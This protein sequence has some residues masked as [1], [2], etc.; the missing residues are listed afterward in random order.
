MAVKHLLQLVILSLPYLAPAHADTNAAGDEITY[1]SDAQV[2][3]RRDSELFN[4]ESLPQAPDS[5]QQL[6]PLVQDSGE[7]GA[8]APTQA[9]SNDLW[10]RIKG[11][12]AMPELRSPFTATHESWYAARP[13]YVRRMVGRSQKYLYHIV[14]EVQKR[15]MPTEIALLP[16]VES[17]FNPQANSTSRASGIWQFIPSTGKHFGLKQDW[18]V[19]NRRDVMAATDAALD[20]LQKLHVMFGSWDLALAA[21]NAGEG[22]VMRAIERNR[23]QG[24][25][26]DYQS[27][28]LPAE[29]K[30]YVPKLQAVKNIVTN[31]EQYGLDIRPIANQPYFTT[32][33]AP[34]QIDAS[35][36]AKLAGISQEEFLALNPE[37]NRPV[38]TSSGPT[39]EFLLPVGKAE[40]FSANLAAYNQPLVS[41]QTYN[42]KRGERQD[43]IARKFGISLAQLRDVNDI[44]GK[45]GK[46]SQPSILLVP[47]QT[48]GESALSVAETATQ[49]P[50]QAGA[51]PD[52]KHHVVKK[53]DSVNS[54]AKRYDMSANS[55]VALNHLKSRKL[56]SGQVLLVRADIANESTVRTRA[57]SAPEKIHYVVRRGDT[58]TEIARKFDVATNDL[59]R[60]NRLSGDRLVPGHKLTIFKPDA[61]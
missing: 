18:W 48:G 53:G 46:L 23:K 31:P 28:S 50:E 3:G 41:W 17:A 14:E 58:L 56:R 40:E 15:G 1:Y 27:L 52:T 4:Y 9:N 5:V 51:T 16:M 37:Y 54:V 47:A 2:Y 39:H 35:L 20:Y 13:D 59:Q 60:W 32:V 11:G 19:D 26:T 30:N 6:P 24:L 55:L 22:T 33:Q 43:A 36:A 34:K 21:Y 8:A 12:Y 44:V 38:L 10:Q 57:S 49:A 25:P 61:A 7:N 45:G 42:A 29:T